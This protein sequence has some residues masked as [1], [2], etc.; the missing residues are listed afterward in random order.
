MTRQHVTFCRICEAYCGMVATVEDGRVSKLRPDEQHL[1]SGGHACPTGVVFNEVTHDPDRVTRPM[2]RNADG[3]FSP[4]GYDE[5]VREIG[6]RLRGIRDAHGPHSVG[7]YYGNPSVFS[8]SHR[9]WAHAF[10]EAVGTRN[11]F[12]AGT[13]DNSADFLA[14]YLL[15]GS[16][17]LQPIPDVERARYMSLWGVNPVVSHGTI[18]N[19]H[20]VRARLRELRKRGGKLVVVDPRFTETAQ[21]AD[22]HHFIRPDSDVFVLLAMARTMLE[23]ELEARVFLRKH[24]RGVDKLRRLVQPF[25]PERAAALSGI[26]AETI[27]QLARELSCA[28]SGCAYGRVACGTWGTHA[29]WALEVCNVLAGKLDQPGGAVFAESPVDVVQLARVAGLDRYARHRSRIGNYPEVL[30]ELP[31]GVLADEILTPGEGQIRALVVSAG[32]PALSIADSASMQ[33]ALRQLECLVSIDIYFNETSTHADYF[34]PATT[35][36]EREDLPLTHLGLMASPY[37][38]WTEPVIAPVGEARQEWRIFTDLTRAMGLPPLGSRLLGFAEGA[39]RAVGRELTPELLVDLLIRLG[40]QGDKLLPWRD[41]LNLAR[42]KAEPHGLHARPARTGVI[43]E[44]LRTE[45]RR[46]NLVP[47]ELLVGLEQLTRIVSEGGEVSSP[48]TLRLIGRRDP[49]SHNTWMHNAPTLMRR[50][51]HRLRINPRDAEAR[52]L[53]DGQ[54]VRVV[55]AAGAV[56]CELRLTDEVMPG[57][58]CLPHGWGHTEARNRVASAEPTPNYNE[59]VDRSVIEPLS[60]MAFLNG[61]EVDVQPLEERRARPASEPA[62]QSASSP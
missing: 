43:G 23:E 15:Y 30:G 37:V 58:V 59:L 18:V 32:N 54:R 22:Q 12:G 13:Q 9:L 21:I 39:L 1:L 5:A 16:H 49:R 51:C 56:T 17:F 35:F 27:R 20:D 7:V 62:A 61:I 25:T 42:I 2:K 60:G 47:E 40:P 31:S 11:A 46:V 34:L 52:G 14:S 19:I 10:R 44:R 29:C 48:K 53:A 33:R 6:A 8:Y 55:G 41:G 24:A 57:V 3:T 4:I 36:L 38:Q 28:A 45:D 50:R 26:D